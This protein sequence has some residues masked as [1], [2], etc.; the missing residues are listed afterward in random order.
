MKRTVS[1]R[2]TSSGCP[3]KK[4]KSRPLT[5]VRGSPTVR[6][7]PTCAASLQYP[8]TQVF[9]AGTMIPDPAPLS[10]HLCQSGTLVHLLEG[11]PCSDLCPFRTSPDCWS[12]SA[13]LPSPPWELP[14]PL[15]HRTVSSQVCP[16][17]S[18][19]LDVTQGRAQ[20]ELELRVFMNEVKE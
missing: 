8:H 7:Q 1:C 6:S 14:Q 20:L 2:A 19:P 18:V 9:Q 4:T 17:H 5:P 12:P 15:S 13:E 3:F 16:V 10:E 11:P